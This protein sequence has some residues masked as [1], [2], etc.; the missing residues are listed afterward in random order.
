MKEFIGIYGSGAPGALDS[1][2][3][4]RR[5]FFRA[6]L[7][8]LSAY[9]VY[10]NTNPGNPATFHDL[11]LSAKRK[12]VASSPLDTCQQ[13]FPEFVQHIRDHGGLGEPC[14]PINADHVVYRTL[15]F[16]IG[17]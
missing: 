12:L 3:Q 17:P 4:L 15:L 11:D 1:C 10:C 16:L 13:F 7:L 5:C 14:L 2:L 8:A 6:S 9:T